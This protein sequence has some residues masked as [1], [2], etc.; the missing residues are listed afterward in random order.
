LARTNQCGQALPIAQ[1]LQS[2]FTEDEIVLEAAGAII[3]ICEENLANPPAVDT[4]L[5]EDESTTTAEVTETPEPEATPT[6]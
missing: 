3:Q 6:P 1:T 4:P 5:A 2:R